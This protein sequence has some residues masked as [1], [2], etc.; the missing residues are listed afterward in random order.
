MQHCRGCLNLMTDWHLDRDMCLTYNPL[1][2]K[3]FSRMT[4]LLVACLLLGQLAQLVHASD[5]A[6]HDDGG[7]CNICLSSQ[8]HDHASSCPNYGLSQPLTHELTL[9]PVFA[10]QGLSTHFSYLS[11]APPP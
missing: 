8:T 11:R 5:V 2:M 10:R 4:L 7:T 1:P 3:R 9:A 6:A